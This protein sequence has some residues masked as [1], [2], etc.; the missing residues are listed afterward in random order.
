MN[1]QLL[2]EGADFNF[3]ISISKNEI[4]K[5]FLDSSLFELL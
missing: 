1:L 5:N 3:C 4:Q 2:Y